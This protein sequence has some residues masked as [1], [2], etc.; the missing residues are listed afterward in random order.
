MYR[1]KVDADETRLTPP[2]QHMLDATPHSIICWGNVSSNLTPTLHIFSGYWKV[3]VS[4]WITGCESHSLLLLIH[5]WK[6][7]AGPRVVTPLWFLWL[8]SRPWGRCHKRTWQTGLGSWGTWWSPTWCCPWMMGSAQCASRCTP[9]PPQ[10][11]PSSS[12][13]SARPW[14]TWR[15]AGAPAGRL[16][17]LRST[18][19]WRRG[20][21]SS[22]SWTSRRRPPGPCMRT[23]SRAAQWCGGTSEGR[24]GA[25]SGG[26]WTLCHL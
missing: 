16:L 2:Y 17:A 5:V 23:R 1:V 24:W 6:V 15:R 10:S 3:K 18:S 4:G 7:P 26:R 25:A 22:W 8:W 12:A 13:G 20:P 19:T 21:C 14:W 11:A 9:A